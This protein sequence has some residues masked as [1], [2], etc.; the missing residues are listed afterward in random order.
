MAKRQNKIVTLYVVG[1]PWLDDDD[2]PLQLMS[3]EAEVQPTRLKLLG[4]RGVFTRYR[5]YV[6]LHEYPRTPKE[7]KQ[8]A[9][10]R[11]ESDIRATRARLQRE[12]ADLLVVRA[13][14]KKPTQS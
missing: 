4:D 13:M 14:L 9:V 8:W 11:L 6:G 5:T 3:I 2:T 12:E 7:A 10:T 1:R